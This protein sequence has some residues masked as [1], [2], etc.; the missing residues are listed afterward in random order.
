M[1]LTQYK[2][3]INA[4]RAA[5]RGKQHGL[6]G[7]DAPYLHAR[8]PGTKATKA[9]GFWKVEVEDPKPVGKDRPFLYLQPNFATGGAALYLFAPYPT[10]LAPQEV[11]V[12]PIYDFNEDGHVEAHHH[13]HKFIGG[14]Y[15][16]AW[17]HDSG[18]V[19]QAATVLTNTK[20][21][22]LDLFDIEQQSLRDMDSSD[23][24]SKYT[25]GHI[26]LTDSIHTDAPT[27]EWTHSLVSTGVK[28][29]R[30]NFGFIGAWQEITQLYPQPNDY[31]AANDN[32]SGGY[33]T[34]P[35]VYAGDTYGVEAAGTLPHYGGRKQF[36][37]PL[38]AAGQGRA[39]CLLAA[40]N[41]RNGAL[42]SG[43]YRMDMELDSGAPML[44][45]GLPIVI[46]TQDHGVTWTYENASFLYPYLR[47]IDASY[48]FP[49][50]THGF[51]SNQQ[52]HYLIEDCFMFYVG[53]GVTLAAVPGIWNS[54]TQ[55][56]NVGMF[57]HNG[58]VWERLEWPGDDWVMMRKSFNTQEPS[59]GST[60]GYYPAWNLASP[61]TKSAGF[62]FGP[63]CVM[64]P[65][66][67]QEGDPVKLPFAYTRDYGETWT[68][69]PHWLDIAGVPSLSG[70][71][72]T[73]LPTVI[74]PY[75]SADEPGRIA[76]FVKNY[77][78]K[79]FLLIEL[80]GLFDVATVSE[81]RPPA[82]TEGFEHRNAVGNVPY[83]NNLAFIYVGNKSNEYPPYVVSALP[84]EYNEVL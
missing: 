41:E 3:P 78:T 69:L 67:V 24:V 70:Y 84:D 21:V 61:L 38:Y 9:G 68:I 44:A 50:D 51:T 6:A 23:D 26:L 80:T 74:K 4:Q 15:V 11:R 8:T 31:G 65:L 59:E 56:Y 27:P 40:Y 76:F 75:L 22:F 45:E 63:G 39:M 30:R 72:V 64:I 29:S 81:I 7:I 57:R 66:R 2:G 62:C 73:S 53:N 83:A 16:A 32:V 17:C 42:I 49:A 25:H 48:G 52:L 13:L 36:V 46:S 19:G 37:S 34:A 60:S 20:I 1:K 28:T 54:L 47:A 14:R 35:Y 5:A 77:D 12:G 58:T 33:R 10:P 82:K 43:T 18:V 71:F 79:D 55:E